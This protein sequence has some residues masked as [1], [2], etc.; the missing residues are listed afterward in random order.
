[1]AVYKDKKTGKWYF[2]VYVYD[3]IKGKRVQKT[4]KGFDLKR[5][6]QEE[7]S[8]FVAEYKQRKYA[9]KNIMI[10]QCVREFLELNK[11]RVKITTYE[12]YK[13]IINIHFTP[14]F[15]N[16]KTNRIN[17]QMVLEWYKYLEELNITNDYKNKILNVITALFD[18]IHK[19]YDI[20]NMFIFQLPKFKVESI[21]KTIVD[22]KI[23]TPQEFEKF[24]AGSNMI[25]FVLFNVLFYTGVRF[26]E[27]R[28]LKWIDYDFK[29]K[30]L[31][32]QRQIYSKVPGKINLELTPK[33]PNSVRKI[34][35]PNKLNDLLYKWKQER[36]MKIGFEDNWFIFGDVKPLGETTIN[37]WKNKLADRNKIHRI[38]IHGFR[39]SYTTMLYYSD[40]RPEVTKELL[41]HESIATTLN[42]Y[43][44]LNEKT[45]ADEVKNKLNK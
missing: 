41:G 1:M 36:M 15:N 12:N 45:I 43:T 25:Q 37:T 10:D 39:H 21:R 4:R 11:K 38:S 30:T 34:W 7:E 23:Y 19:T 9:Y 14:H 44:H 24:I 27:L 20:K 2:R 33:T 31:Y 13:S 18:F 32:I 5:Q 16:I 22:K 42:T 40:F 17:R 29:E 26:G 6:A 35:I 3:E 8:I 28:G